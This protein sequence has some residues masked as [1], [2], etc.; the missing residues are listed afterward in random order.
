MDKRGLGRSP[1]SRAAQAPREP[2]ATFRVSLAEPANDN[3][4]PLS[5]RVVEAGKWAVLL[6]AVIGFAAYLMR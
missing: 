4:A 3:G 6:A 5:A 1:G 2:A